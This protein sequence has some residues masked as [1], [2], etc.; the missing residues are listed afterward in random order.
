VWRRDRG[1]AASV[2]APDGAAEIITSGFERIEEVVDE[3]AVVTAPGCERS[4]EGGE[5]RQVGGAGGR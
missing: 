5:R 1:D 3:W 4:S 2:E